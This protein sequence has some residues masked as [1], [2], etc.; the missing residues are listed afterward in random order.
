MRKRTHTL[1]FGYTNTKM[2]RELTGVDNITLKYF[3]NPQYKIIGAGHDT[4]MDNTEESEAA[5]D[6][7]ARSSPYKDRIKT[8]VGNL[9]DETPTA[10]TTDKL[11]SIFRAFI[12]ECVSMYR[13]I[14]KMP[15]QRD[16]S[17]IDTDD[18]AI[19]EL[20]KDL[21]KQIGTSGKKVMEEFVRYNSV[22]KLS[23]PPRIADNDK[24]SL[25]SRD[26]ERNGTT[27]PKENKIHKESVGKKVVKRKK[28]KD[29][30]TTDGTTDK[31]KGAKKKKKSV[32][33]KKK[34]TQ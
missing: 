25:Y 13:T 19:H 7:F 8:L 6:F 1:F 29:N 34:G 18:I 24:I 32:G 33:D 3:T 11:E 16:I 5:D 31:K 17:T 12:N 4:G 20:D 21:V 28:K 30:G 23:E 22:S 15:Q 10:E 14:D 9:L 26:T 27:N 2:S